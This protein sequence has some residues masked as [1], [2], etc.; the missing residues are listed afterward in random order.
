MALLYE[1]EH[2]GG[3]CGRSHI[4]SFSGATKLKEQISEI[5]SEE[6][7]NY[8]EYESNPDYGDDSTLAGKCVEICLTECQCNYKL[9]N[10]SR[11][12]IIEEVG[13]EEVYRFLNPNSGNIVVVFLYS[14]NKVEK[15]D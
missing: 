7:D 14:S 12:Q 4:F 11:K 3:C 15:P 1:D 10:K 13:F 9:G 2:A 5:L 8:Q 6:N